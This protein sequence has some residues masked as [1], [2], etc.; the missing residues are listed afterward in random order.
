MPCCF[1]P[2]AANAA[3]EIVIYSARNEQ[4]IAAVRRLYRRDRHENPLHH[5][6]G[7]AV[8]RALKR[9][10]REHARG[11]AHHRGRRQPVARGAR[12]HA[13]QDRF[14]DTKA[15]IPAQLRDPDGHWFGLSVRAR[16][17]VYHTARMK[18]AELSTY[19]D[20]ASPKWKG[21]L[22]LRT[23]KKVYNQS[24][25][26]MMIARLG[27]EQTEKIV[28]GWVANLATAPF[29]DDTKEMEAIA[30]GQCD[31]GIVNTYYY[32]RLMKKN[33]SCRSRCSG[34]IRRI[35]ACT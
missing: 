14:G 33:R 2:A 25:I 15:N 29:P 35:A 11:Y 24:L 20:L 17:V 34:R 10:G 28:R 1:L 3:D 6:Q 9:R 30:A 19:E 27:E 21:R 13:R 31:V 4:L 12:R 5:R 7:R 8:A 32:G 16:T 23:S 18:P 22:C 26:A